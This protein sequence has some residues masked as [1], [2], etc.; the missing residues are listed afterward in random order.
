MIAIV[1]RLRLSSINGKT[2]LWTVLIPEY[3]RTCAQYL[4]TRVEVGL[5]PLPL[6]LPRVS[7]GVDAA[8]FSSLDSIPTDNPS[9]LAVALRALREAHV[10]ARFHF[11]GTQHA[12]LIVDSL[13]NTYPTRHQIAFHLHSLFE[14]M[15]SEW[16]RVQSVC[17]AFDN[18]ALPPPNVIYA[19]GTDSRTAAW[20][21][22]I[23]QALQRA[24]TTRIPPTRLQVLLG[25]LAAA[26][27]YAPTERSRHHAGSHRTNWSDA[28]S[29]HQPRPPQQVPPADSPSKRPLSD[30]DAHR[31]GGK[32]PRRR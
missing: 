15:I 23:P 24:P 4:L 11:D 5:P 25:R 29:S 30:R 21:R 10:H 8:W 13:Y 32:R 28:R 17:R 26:Q 22:S 1:D 20:L 9:P 12:M 19:T 18:L 2:S 31:D 14:D 3:R 27:R 16:N 6:P 7:P